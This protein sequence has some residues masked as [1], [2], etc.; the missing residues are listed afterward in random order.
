MKKVIVLGMSVMFL[1][2]CNNTPEKSTEKQKT[3]SHEAHQHD[4]HVETIELNNNEKWVVNEEMK[5]FV[6]KG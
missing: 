6:T 1:W 3:E 5:P 4:E 2:S